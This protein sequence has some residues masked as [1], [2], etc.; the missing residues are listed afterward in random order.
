MYE[1]D[2]A[3]LVGLWNS[4]CDWF[5]YAGGAMQPC[6]LGMEFIAGELAASLSSVQK[7][8][9]SSVPSWMVEH[10]G[11]VLRMHGFPG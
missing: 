10:P 1:F 8:T 2:H 6:E 9:V 3:Q 11:V 4:C 5:H 7:S